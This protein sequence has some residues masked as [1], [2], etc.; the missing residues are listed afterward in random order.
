MSYS[1]YPLPYFGHSSV[2]HPLIFVFSARLDHSSTFFLYSIRIWDLLFARLNHSSILFLL[3][4]HSHLN[5]AVLNYAVGLFD[6][7]LVL[8]LHLGLVSST[9]MRVSQSSYHSI[10]TGEL[11]LCH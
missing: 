6:L 1:F 9:R 4:R 10:F 11:F 7:L 8:Y 5:Y 3:S 2:A